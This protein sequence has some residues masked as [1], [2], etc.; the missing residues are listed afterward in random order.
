MIGS[1]ALKLISYFNALPGK[2]VVLVYA[3]WT[4][5]YTDL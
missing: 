2:S 4:F 3:L 5:S 1:H